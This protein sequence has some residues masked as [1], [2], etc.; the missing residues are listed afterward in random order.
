MKKLLEKAKRLGSRKPSMR[1]SSTLTK[2]ELKKGAE[3]FVRRYGADIKKL[4]AE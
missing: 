3:E 1:P 2:E 4:S